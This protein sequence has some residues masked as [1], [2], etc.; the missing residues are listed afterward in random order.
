VGI[1]RTFLQS[2][3]LVQ[4]VYGQSVKLPRL[5]EKTPLSFDETKIE[6]PLRFVE[7]YTSGQASTIKSFWLLSRLAFDIT[8]GQPLRIKGLHR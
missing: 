8:Q 6:N 2:P 7:T 4:E 3:R 5:D 1:V